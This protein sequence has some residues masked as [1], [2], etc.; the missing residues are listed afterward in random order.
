MVREVEQEKKGK[1]KLFFILY[2]SSVRRPRTPTF[3]RETAQDEPFEF[4]RF[5]S[6]LVLPGD[7]T[8]HSVMRDV[9]R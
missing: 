4:H 5:P 2:L 9:T 1:K 3:V 6:I 8:H 7:V